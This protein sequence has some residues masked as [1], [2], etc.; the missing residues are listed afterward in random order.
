MEKRILLVDD[1][2]SLRRSL[3]MGLNQR[4]IAVENCETGHCALNKLE[5]F[6]QENIEL[7]SI[8]LDILLP[9]INGVELGK[10]IKS[11][12]PDTPVIFITGYADKVKEDIETIEAGQILEKPFTVDQLA[13]RFNEVLDRPETIQETV[14][15][16]KS[17]EAVS[18][19]A[20]MML[21]VNKE[22]DFFSIYRELYFMDNVLYCDATQGD[23]DIILLVHADSMDVCNEIC[24][25]K[26]RTI[27][28]IDEVDFMKIGATPGNEKIQEIVTDAD[29]AMSE[30]KSRDRNFAQ[31]VCS[32]VLI[33]LENDKLEKIH[34]MLNTEENVAFCDVTSGKYNLVLMV[35]GSY[36]TEVDR[37]VESKIIGLDGVLKV[38]KYP[39]VNMFE[40]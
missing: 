19:S 33:E 2:S 7:D 37:F 26:I 29:I 24:E 39:I 16:E 10:M 4:G 18:K 8:V 21:K 11:K 20:F 13:E 35:H 31:H 1:E 32:Y 27:D 38:K 3:T 40:M 15:P 36:F 14:I 22:A 30:D 25:K 6:K 34:S 17:K 12:Y 28:G 5:S 9:D 23:Y